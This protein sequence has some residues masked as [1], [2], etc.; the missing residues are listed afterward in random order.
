M[1]LPS[2]IPATD[3]P[4]Q[5]AA[6]TN[7]EAKPLPVPQPD[8]TPERATHRPDNT[9]NKIGPPWLD[10]ASC[11]ARLNEDLAPGGRFWRAIDAIGAKR[12]NCVPLTVE[13]EQLFTFFIKDGIDRKNF[14]ISCGGRVAGIVAA[15]GSYIAAMERG[16]AKG[17][18]AA[19]QTLRKIGPCWIHIDSR[20]PI[21]KE[22]FDLARQLNVAKERRQY[23][24]GLAYLPS[25]QGAAADYDGRRHLNSQ[26]QS[27]PRVIDFCRQLDFEHPAHPLVFKVGGYNAYYVRPKEWHALT[28]QMQQEIEQ[29]DVQIASLE[30]RAAEAK[31]IAD[32]LVS[33][34]AD[35]YLPID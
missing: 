29:L 7:V 6:Q 4:T 2:V 23:L 15:Q 20:N 13:E 24:A 1:T 17:A 16:D 33:R 3:E 34:V 12:H 31:R 5:Q 22:A 9:V 18:E 19:R 30:P 35:S 32:E 21:V 10:S 8:S 25:K 11:L 27:D 28:L 14:I 26:D